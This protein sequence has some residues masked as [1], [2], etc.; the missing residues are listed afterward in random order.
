MRLKSETFS[1]V[2]CTTESSEY[3]S[4]E[5]LDV[6]PSARR[7]TSNLESIKSISRVPDLFLSQIC[8]DEYKSLIKINL[9]AEYLPFRST[10]IEL[11]RY[12]IARTTLS[13]HTYFLALMYLDDVL[14]RISV[15]KDHF[16]LVAICCLLLAGIVY[17][18]FVSEAHRT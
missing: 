12:T 13:I 17:K 1:T 18:T 7:S 15:P 9:K 16:Q 4:R 10:L 6:N 14:G 11:I 8:D 2:K 5:I 3:S